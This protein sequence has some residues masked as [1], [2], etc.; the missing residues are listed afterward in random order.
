MAATKK[1]E[2]KG[3]WRQRQGQIG[4]NAVERVV[5]N[6]WESRWQP[7]DA[8]NDDGVDGLIFIEN[9]GEL[10]GQTIY[11]QVKCSKK[12]A[13]DGTLKFPL[14]AEKAERNMKRWR[15]LVGAAIVVLVNPKD[16]K[17]YWADLRHPSTV[18]GTQIFVSE[19][20]V[21]D[22]SAKRKIANLCGTLHLDLMLP[23]VITRA[24]DFA[25]LFEKTP[26]KSAARQLYRQVNDS[27]LTFLNSQHRISF[28]REGW[29]HINRRSRSPLA[30]MQT[31]NLMGALKKIVQKTDEKRLRATG[32]KING[33]VDLVSASATVVFPHRQSGV[34]TVVF[35]RR[36]DGDG[37]FNYSFHTLYEA[38]RKR[39]L[40][41]FGGHDPYLAD[42][43]FPT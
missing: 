11:V 36:K 43:P 15:H 35:K 6:D 5:L 24:P 12:A 41:G 20:N 39:D 34:V 42:E 18:K 21:F 8:T 2:K 7:I 27:G 23:T 33:S 38:R 37:A 3:L 22:R 26:L 9:G 10:T 1:R 16:A 28:T 4:V 25:Y 29:V 32:S 40:W 14:G 31:Y 19:Q 17:A 30:R 13:K